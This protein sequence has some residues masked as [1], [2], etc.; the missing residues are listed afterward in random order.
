MRVLKNLVLVSALTAAGFAQANDVRSAFEASTERW[1]QAFNRGDAQAVAALYADDAILMPPTDTT[2]YTRPAIEAFWEGLLAQ[3]FGEHAIDIVD[4][5]VQ[6]DLAYVAGV[7]SATQAVSGGDKAYYG[8][9]VLS[10]FQRQ[11]DGSWKAKLHS[12]N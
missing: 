4:V 2:V 9:N 11:G 3:G 7:W 10:V 6:G 5:K 1:N 12:W 8:G